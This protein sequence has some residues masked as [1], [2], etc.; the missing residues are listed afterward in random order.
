MFTC[1]DFYFISFQFWLLSGLQASTLSNVALIGTASQSSTNYGGVASRAI[2][3]NPDSNYY[4]G[5]CT[6]TSY[7][8]SHW[9]SLLLPAMYRITDISITNSNANGWRISNA[10]ILIGNSLENNGNNNPRCSVIPSIPDGGTRTFNCGGMIGRLINVKL[11]STHP[12]SALMICELEAYGELAPP[13]PSFS[14]VVMGRSVAVVEKKLCWS[15]ALFYCRDFYWDL[16]S[17]RS[18]E[19]QREVEEV[20]KSVS[21]PL[22]EHVWLGL[23]RY[24]MGDTWFWMSG[25]TKN[26]TYF[27]TSSYW[28]DTSPCGAMDTSDGFHWKDRPCA[29]HLHFIC[30]KDIQSDKNV[31]FYSSSRP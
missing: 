30:L 16:L 6:H 22:T 11:E 14:A 27:E 24:L 4:S 13:A 3:G 20:L 18:E 5:S 1:R 10:E 25:A 2:D 8:P 19:E 28:A 23:R 12:S 21:F 31:G 15:D 17:V 26:F 9:W 7:G 29:E